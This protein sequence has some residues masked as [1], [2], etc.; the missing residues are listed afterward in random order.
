MVML[1]TE[2]KRPSRGG[3]RKKKSYHFIQKILISFLFPL[4]IRNG[5][6]YK[7]RTLYSYMEKQRVKIGHRTEAELT[8]EVVRDPFLLEII[9]TE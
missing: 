8:E 3:G 9:K 4:R 7:G 2:T 6:Y 1:I 5:F